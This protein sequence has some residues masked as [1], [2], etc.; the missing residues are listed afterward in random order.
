MLPLLP[1]QLG[2]LF[3]AT[4][5]VAFSEGPPGTPELVQ[6]AIDHLLLRELIQIIQRQVNAK[7]HLNSCPLQ[8]VEILRILGGRLMA[9]DRRKCPTP[10]ADRNVEDIGK[11][12]GT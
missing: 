2:P 5:W 9:K 1:I 7:I 3:R 4:F 11:W 12:S 6:T 8:E 10:T